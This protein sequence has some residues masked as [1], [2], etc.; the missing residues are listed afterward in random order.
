MDLN[1]KGCKDVNKVHLINERVQYE[2][3]YKR[4][5]VIKPGNFLTS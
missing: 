3:D 4:S 5:D 2:S 1:D